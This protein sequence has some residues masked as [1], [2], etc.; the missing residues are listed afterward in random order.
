MDFEPGF[1]GFRA[2][3]AHVV[4]AFGGTLKAHQAIA[5]NHFIF[6]LKNIVEHRIKSGTAERF[7]WI[8]EPIT[9]ATDAELD[10]AGESAL[11]V[12]SRVPQKPVLAKAEWNGLTLELHEDIAFLVGGPYR[13]CVAMAGNHPRHSSRT[14]KVEE[15]WQVFITDEAKVILDKSYSSS[16]SST[17]AKSAAGAYKG[18]RKIVET[19]FGV[20]FVNCDEG[21]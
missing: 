3:I 19:W 9:H 18:V 13:L 8:R 1:P 21:V 4:A 7:L 20:S 15:D 16:P 10:A 5:E 11:R 12:L 14:N 17:H 2:R 6:Q